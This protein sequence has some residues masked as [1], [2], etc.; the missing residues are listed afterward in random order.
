VIGPG[1]AEY[2]KARATF[3]GGIDRRPAAIIRAVDA[4]EV[5]R[6][7]LLAREAGLELAIRSGGHSIAGHS[8]S[9]GGLVLDLSLMH[10]IDIDVAQRTAWAQ[11]GLTTGGYTAAAAKHG[12][13]TGFGDTGTVGVGGITLGGGI[14]FLARKH[15][16]TIDD[17]LAAEIVTADGQVLQVDAGTHP[18][19]FWAIRGGGG[20]FGVATRFK[21][22]LH[23]LPS[24]VGGMLFLPVTADIIHA[25]VSEASAA[26]RELTTIVNIMPA[27]P[28][29][30]IPA[31]YHGKFVIMAFMVYAGE[32][33]AGQRAIA[34]FRAL[35]TPIADMVRPMTYPEMFMPEQ[36]DYH[37]MAVG[38]TM[39][40]DEVSK[41]MAETIIEHLKTGTAKMPVTQIRVLG[42]AVSHVPNEATAYAH[43]GQ[44]IMLNAAAV[45][46]D[47]EK[48]SEYQAW[49]SRYVEALDP[50]DTS[51]YVN[52]LGAEG[53]ARV[54]DAYPAATWDRLCAIKRQYDPT[55]VFRLNQNIPPAA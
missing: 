15:G 48:V 39:Y 17:L 40:V 7:V 32:T 37:P 10:G 12:L 22:R 26:P 47:A 55:N 20:N 53:A 42:G 54:R 5:A 38:R 46:E 9:Q 34:P 36:P 4:A 25:F 27:M 18:D 51:A 13:A 21:F 19:L 29:P 23:E 16:L 14:G 44:P 52:F 2:D 30:F 11:S 1:D 3:Y 41:P 28:M 35:A 8:M 50:P 33:E 45:Y 43:R 31:E 49:L 6:V 24:I